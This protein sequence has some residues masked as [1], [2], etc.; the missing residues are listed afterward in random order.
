MA[1]D[2]SPTTGK[3]V[4]LSGP[5]GVSLAYG[6]DGALLTSRT[7]TGDG[8]GA[9]SGTVQW[10]YNNDFRVASESI[11]GGAAVTFGYDN[12]GLLNQ[13]GG[14]SLFRHPQNGLYTG[15]SI[16][17]VSDTVTPDAYG[18]V[19]TY[20]AQVSGSTIYQVTYT[21]DALGRI[22][23]MTET[24]Q[25]QT[26]AYE[27]VYDLVGRL[28]DVYRDS[29]L[30]AHYDYDVNGNRSARTSS[31]GTEVGT[32]D[33]QD[34]LLT[35]ATKTY[36]MS[37]AGD[38]TSVTDAVTG[39]TTAFTHDAGGKLRHVELPDGTDIDYLVDGEG[40]RIWKQRN[41][42]NVQGFLYRS[43]LQP[44]A[45][46]DGAGGVVARFVYGRG[47]NVPDLMIKGGATYRILT[48]H[49]GSPRLV[50]NTANGV[51]AQRMD[52]DE[53]GRVLM[54][55]SPGFQ[56]FG[57]AGGLYDRD[58][59][60]VRFG[61]RDYDPETGR[62]TAK[63][64]IYFD[65][66]SSN[67]YEYAKGDPVNHRDPS[68]LTVYEC[69]A[70]AETFGPLGFLLPYHAWV[71]TDSV[72]GGN[73][74]LPWAMDVIEHDEQLKSDLYPDE[75]CHEITSADEACVTERLWKD[76]KDQTWGGFIGPWNSCQAY[77]SDVLSSCD[78]APQSTGVY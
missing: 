66:G 76:I 43:D 19:A 75:T 22:E 74:G 68:G 21:P 42:V 60:F 25:G 23:N 45:E 1:F 70:P 11:N 78:M 47:R 58:T 49:R 24:I 55:T 2:Y 67:I 12:D 15:S 46:L 16:G 31:G 40:H 33:D 6:Y 38:R 27:Y 59:G 14:L 73:S 29:V 50:V 36:G 65:G 10:I 72:C 35:Y 8:F 53:F 57:F 77:A 62:W 18:A 30:T 69:F 13:A 44:A 37:P 56:P 7:W 61:E 32:Y 64:P 63:D 5:S 9:G 28:T 41:G 54:D 51:V 39:G 48:D 34:R 26:H 4:N 17:I 3:L 52:F 20:V 71:C